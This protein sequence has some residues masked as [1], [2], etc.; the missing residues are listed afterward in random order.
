M[1]CCSHDY[2]GCTVPQ[3]PV[4]AR[5]DAGGV[6]G[7]AAEAAVTDLLAHACL[8]LTATDSS[9][10]ELTGFLALCTPP[11]IPY[12]LPRDSIQA[13][14]AAWVQKLSEQHG[15]AFPTA[16]AAPCLIL[17]PSHEQEALSQL[18][19]AAIKLAPSLTTIIFLSEGPVPLSQ[20]HLATLFTSHPSS[21]PPPGGLGG[22]VALVATRDTVARPVA[23]RRA[24]VEDCD[25]LMPLVA[26]AQAAGGSLGMVR[27]NSA[28]CG[29]AQ[30]SSTHRGSWR[31]D[32]MRRRAMMCTWRTCKLFAVQHAARVSSIAKDNASQPAC[33]CAAD[34]I[35]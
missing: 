32:A 26:T 21:A 6:A 25:D 23:A 16:L 1:M 35:R 12:L 31:C 19:T 17:H 13:D 2:T 5:R 4:H 28:L 11:S 10:G 8:A 9:T 27:A 18:L 29:T 15:L 3:A 34:S 7:V 33:L 22:V 24:R 20:P 30:H 14:A